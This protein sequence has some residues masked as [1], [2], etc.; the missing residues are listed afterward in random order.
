[1]ACPKSH[2]YPVTLRGQDWNKL[3]AE[4]AEIVGS[5]SYFKKRF[6]AYLTNL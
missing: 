3:S 5:A 2:K 1:M 4:I 6:K